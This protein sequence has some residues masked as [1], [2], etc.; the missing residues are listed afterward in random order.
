MNSIK[1][2]WSVKD[3]SIKCY[4]LSAVSR[5]PN[6]FKC[7]FDTVGLH[8]PNKNGNFSTGNALFGRKV[9][10]CVSGFH[11]PADV[12]DRRI[13]IS[14]SIGEFFNKPSKSKAVASISTLICFI[15]GNGTL[16]FNN[17]RGT[18]N[19]WSKFS[20][21]AGNWNNFGSLVII[22]KRI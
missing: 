4:L 1:I 21:S 5:Q 16:T 2:S 10:V 11:E 14:N 9:F 8:K 19:N 6:E 22:I 7:L 12:V 15:F 3:I 13:L 18:V 20:V 17:E